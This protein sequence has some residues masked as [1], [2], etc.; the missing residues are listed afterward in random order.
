MTTPLPIPTL[1]IA[2][3]LTLP[4]GA[5]LPNRLAKAAMTE[6]LADPQGRATAELAR[7]YGVWADG[8]AGL[9]IKADPVFRHLMFYADPAKPYF[10]LEPQ[11]NAPCAFNRIASGRQQDMGVFVLDPGQTATGRVGFFPFA[12]ELR[13]S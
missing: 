3:S 6:G 10:C 13:R 2:D 5:V 4:C 7:L 11:S 12:L 1:N 8:G 9:L